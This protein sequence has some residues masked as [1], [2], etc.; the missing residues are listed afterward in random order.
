MPK[1]PLS[2]SRDLRRKLGELFDAVLAGTVSPDRAKAGA[3]VAAQIIE[4][5]RYDLELYETAIEMGEIQIEPMVGEI[6][7]PPQT[8]SLTRI[9][10]TPVIRERVVQLLSDRGAMKPRLIADE[11]DV[12]PKQLAAALDHEWFEKTPQGYRMAE[13]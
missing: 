6:T 8:L 3:V 1:F 7:G 10:D 9:D 2:P 11:L 4:C 12:E 5:A 13:S